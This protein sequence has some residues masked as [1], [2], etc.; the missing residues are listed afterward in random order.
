VRLEFTVPGKASPSGSKK[1]FLHPKTKKIVV[2]DTAKGKDSW[3]ARV[4]AFAAMARPGLQIS[5]SQ[6]MGP[7]A[8]EVKFHFQRPKSHFRTGRN[9]G[10][11][12]DTASHHHTGKPDLTKLIRCTEDA[13]TGVLFRDDSQVVHRL[14]TKVWSENDQV[15]IVVVWLAK[16]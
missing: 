16:P 14:A 7:V 3:Q 9:S 1:A 4:S 2:M 5:D 15:E 11:L 12:K 8:M 6:F 13:M 10:L